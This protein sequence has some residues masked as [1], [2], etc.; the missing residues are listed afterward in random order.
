MMDLLSEEV[1]KNGTCFTG[2]VTTANTS[3]AAV[4]YYDYICVCIIDP[5]G[6]ITPQPMALKRPFSVPSLTGR[7]E[8]QTV[9]CALCRVSYL[10]A[11]S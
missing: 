3:T 6:Q 8:K 11:W 1:W 10:H 9:G 2:A 4:S 5:A 7:L